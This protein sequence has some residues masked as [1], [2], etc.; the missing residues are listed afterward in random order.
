MTLYNIF[1]FC[2]IY[3]YVRFS[4]TACL[5]LLTRFIIFRFTCSFLHFPSMTIGKTSELKKSLLSKSWESFGTEI[6]KK[7]RITN[8]GACW[9]HMT[10]AP[11]ATL[12]A[13]IS[14]A[15][16]LL[17]RLQ[18]F[19]R[20]QKSF[21]KKSAVFCG[22]YIQKSIALVWTGLTRCLFAT[23]FSFNFWISRYSFR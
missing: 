3:F 6:M 2:V 7:L 9:Y 1:N 23:L 22:L 5:L 8:E 21:N 20:R 17:C 4:S 13:G 12:P 11:R 15:K 10:T 16:N 19:R 14:N 18:N